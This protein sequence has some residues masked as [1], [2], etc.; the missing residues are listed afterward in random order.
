MLCRSIVNFQ[1]NEYFIWL[2]WYIFQ[3][4]KS[5]NRPLPLVDPSEITPTEILD[6]KLIVRGDH[7]QMPVSAVSRPHSSNVPPQLVQNGSMN[8]P[9]TSNVARSNSLR[10]SSPPRIRR[11]L[12]NQANVPPAVPEEG[13]PVPPAPQQY[14]SLRRDQNNFAANKPVS[15]SPYDWSQRTHEATIRQLGET[16]DNQPTQITYQNL[17]NAN[18]ISYQHHQHNHPAPVHG[19]N[20]NSVHMSKWKPT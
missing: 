14:P 2:F 20:G 15:D 1:T 17:Q 13:P 8:L 11:D 6:L 16:N 4:L 19:S 18:N 7:R 9:K 5:T 12:R 10:S 3:I